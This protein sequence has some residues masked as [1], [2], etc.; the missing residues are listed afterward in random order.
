MYV[1]RSPYTGDLPATTMAEIR[2]TDL[3]H[4]RVIV[5]FD[6]SVVE[7][8]TERHASVQRLHR[9]MLV[10]TVTGPDRHERMRV[11]LS[12]GRSA[13]A[14]FEAT[15]DAQGWAATEPFWTDLQRSAAS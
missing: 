7:V 6:G 3:L 5:T 4:D 10:V 2:Y 14:G 1:G 15:L 8:F 13:G 9:G 12:T 11:G